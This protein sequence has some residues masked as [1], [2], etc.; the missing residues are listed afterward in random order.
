MCVILVWDNLMTLKVEHIWVGKMIKMKMCCRAL[1]FSLVLSLLLQTKT[2][3]A[4]EHDHTVSPLKL[5]WFSLLLIF[6]SLSVRGRWRGC[7]VDE[8]G[9][10]LS[11]STGDVRLL[12]FAIL[13]RPQANDLPLPW[14]TRRGTSRCWAGVLWPANWIQVYVAWIS[15]KVT[16]RCSIGF[17]LSAPVARTEFCM[18]HLD[19]TKLKSFLYAVKNHYW[20]QMYIDD[21][22]IWGKKSHLKMSYFIMANFQSNVLLQALS[23]KWTRKVTLC[24]SGRTKSWK[25]DLMG[26]RWKIM[27]LYFRHQFAG[28]NFKYSFRLST[29]TSRP[30]HA[31]NW[32][33]TPNCHSPMKW[34]GNSQT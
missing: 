31:W 6:N 28:S 4:D 3:L 7:F 18:V 10:P 27:K 2:T 9:G 15:L 1:K 17:F 32:S 5:S 21:L 11:Q 29:S 23:A 24:T 33:L 26:N 20:Y 34:F 30:S 22:P 8:H 25:L 12:F 19:E 13:S 16:R 14:D